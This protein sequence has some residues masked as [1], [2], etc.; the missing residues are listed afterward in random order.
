[1]Q[2]CVCNQETRLTHV[3]E[4]QVERSLQVIDVTMTMHIHLSLCFMEVGQAFPDFGQYE[5]EAIVVRLVR[6]LL[7]RVSPSGGAH[8]HGD[9]TFPTSDS[10]LGAGVA[11]RREHCVTCAY[12]VFSS[13][14][15]RDCVRFPWLSTSF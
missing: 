10:L 11:G 4:E 15:C 12:V 5:P 1:M 13:V 9:H 14:D 7:V 2:D 3:P 6:Y 8:Y